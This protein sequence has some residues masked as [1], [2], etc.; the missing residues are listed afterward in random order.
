VLFRSYYGE[1]NF[2]PKQQGEP[3]ERTDAERIELLRNFVIKQVA[4]GA[5]IELQDDFSAVLVW[6]KK[7]NHIL[8]L[9]LSLVTFGI[10]IIIWILVAMTSGE[11]RRLYKIDKFG[12]I[13]Y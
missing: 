9:L 1:K 2:Q 13:R 7:P 12:F 4:N 5:S 8:H 11:T 10:W 3:R 6:G